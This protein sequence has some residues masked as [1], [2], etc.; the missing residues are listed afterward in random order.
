MAY[1]RSKSRGAK[2]PY[3]KKVS[4]AVLLKKTRN[5][6]RMFRPITIADT[7]VTKLNP[8]KPR[9]ISV[10]KSLKINADAVESSAATNGFTI[11]STGTAATYQVNMVFDP[12]GCFGNN[13]GPINTSVGTGSLVAAAIPEWSSYAALYSKYKVKK[14]HLHFKCVST[15]SLTLAVTSPT[16][17]IRYLNEYNPSSVSLITI[18]EERNWV[19][20]VFTP[21]QP[22]FKY[23]FYPKCMALNDNVNILSTDSRIP[24]SMKFTSTSTPVELYGASI[25][26]AIPTNS[27]QWVIQCD[28]TYDMMFQEQN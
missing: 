15:A 12:A 14:V 1:T 2:K 4:V 9:I 7:T 27:L 21:E 25:Y 16:L 23:S 19:R 28:V 20:K 10:I 6:R 13:S 17:Y 24:V 11:K 26:V 22:D 5:P 3:K 8:G 18:S